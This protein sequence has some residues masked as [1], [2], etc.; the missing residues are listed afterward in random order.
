[1]QV[2]DLLRRFN[3][4]QAAMI[5]KER[6]HGATVD[7]LLLQ[8]FA[9]EKDLIEVVASK[10]KDINQARRELSAREAELKEKGLAVERALAEVE[11]LERVMGVATLEFEVKEQTL[12]SGL[13]TMTRPGRGRRARPGGDPCGPRAHHPGARQPRRGERPPH[14]RAGED[15][16]QDGRRA[17]VHGAGAG[18]AGTEGRRARTGRRPRSA[19]LTQE[20][21]QAEARSTA[22]VQGLEQR[23]F[24]PRPRGRTSSSSSST[25]ASR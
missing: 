22:Q 9:T 8:K 13:A 7:D 20:H 2:D 11:R 1:M 19:R 4:A 3:E 18:D 16:G 6:E 21:E 24:P 12:S 14:R 5:Q 23:L 10:E 15:A 17:R 25:S